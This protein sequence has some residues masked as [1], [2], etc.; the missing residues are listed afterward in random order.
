MALFEGFGLLGF[1]FLMLS[2]LVF[3]VFVVILWIWA[4]VDCVGSS[5]K[6]EEKLLWIILVILVPFIGAL[7]YFILAKRLSKEASEKGASPKRSR[8]GKQKVLVRDTSNAVIAGVCSGLARYLDAD[9]VLI[10][11]IWVVVT[12]FTGFWPGI[13]IYLIAWAIM[14]ER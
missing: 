1:P 8:R 10:R 5:L 12:I 3:L 2:F 13:V 14:P 6:T 7:L 11:L 4:I 9:P